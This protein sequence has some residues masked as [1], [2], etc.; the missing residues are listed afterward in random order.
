MEIK[1]ERVPFVFD[2][3]ISPITQEIIGNYLMSKHRIRA[4][5]PSQRRKLEERA[6]D[7]V[8]N[9]SKCFD[10]TRWFFYEM[11]RQN[12][13]NVEYSEESHTI[14]ISGFREEVFNINGK[15][16]FKMSQDHRSTVIPVRKKDDEFN[17]E[18]FD[19]SQRVDMPLF[20]NLRVFYEFNTEIYLHG[21]F[22]KDPLK[23][24]RH[25]FDG[26]LSKTTTVRFTYG[27]PGELI[28]RYDD[29]FFSQVRRKITAPIF[30][31]NNKREGINL[32]GKVYIG[33]DFLY[34]GIINSDGTFPFFFRTDQKKDRNY[35]PVPVPR[36]S[37]LV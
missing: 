18:I 12:Y 3:H 14:F 25:D 21:N 8:K 29:E 15:S 1:E 6:S 26:D 5:I 4:L 32:Q 31:L 17:L 30:I 7:K 11:T 22:T 16:N 34:Q 24:S 13:C 35:N 20:G 33:N 10:I 9:L 2:E 23:A 19:I 27:S 37:V 36:E 28:Y